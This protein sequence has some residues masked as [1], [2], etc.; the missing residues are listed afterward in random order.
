MVQRNAMRVIDEGI[1]F[2]ELIL[3]D[4]DIRGYLSLQEID[5]CFDLDKYLKNIDVVFKRL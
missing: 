5:D 3:N 2:R 1:D 4:Q